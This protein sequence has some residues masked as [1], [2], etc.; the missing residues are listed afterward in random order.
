MAFVGLLALAGGG[1]VTAANIASA[2]TATSA[3]TPGAP[4]MQQNFDPHKGGHMGANGMKEELL[5]SETADKVTAA[6]LAAQPGA[7][8][9]RVETDAEGAAYEAH[10]VAAD[11][12]HL[13]LKFDTN[14]TVTATETG[15]SGRGP[16]GMP[17]AQSQNQAG[18]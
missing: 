10:L 5:T 4:A 2:D 3:Q 13:T 17:G 18:N 8:I 11:G 16:G 1:L 12:S 6:A 7:T 14:Y 9:E 15:P